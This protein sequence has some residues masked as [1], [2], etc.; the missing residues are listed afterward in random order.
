MP[1]FLRIL[2]RRFKLYDQVPNVIDEKTSS[3]EVVEAERRPS[4]SID[5][6]VNESVKCLNNKRDFKV[7]QKVDKTNPG[8]LK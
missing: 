2:T 8:P 7:G 6:L 3:Q 1:R 5:Q 4:V